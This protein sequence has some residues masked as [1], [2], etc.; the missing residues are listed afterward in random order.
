MLSLPDTTIVIRH[1]LMQCMTPDQMMEM[2]RFAIFTPSICK[3]CGLYHS[4]VSVEDEDQVADLYLKPIELYAVAKEHLVS[5]VTY[6]STVVTSMLHAEGV[7]VIEETVQ[8]E[9]VV[10]GEVLRRYSYSD[11]VHPGPELMMTE[12]VSI[13]TT[14][15]QWCSYGRRYVA[16]SVESCTSSGDDLDYDIH[17]FSA[18]PA[19]DMF[20]VLEVVNRL[21]HQPQPHAIIFS[22]FGV[23]SSGAFAGGGFPQ[24]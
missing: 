18:V 8:Y 9:Y 10:A 15:T 1:E 3:E 14:V 20:E 19:H 2:D 24:R 5:E 11:D 16:Q 23:G 22:P 6:S 17:S 4:F 12:F 21:K 7:G 13:S